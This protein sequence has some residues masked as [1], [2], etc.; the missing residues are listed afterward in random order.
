MASYSFYLF[1]RSIESF[2]L[3]TL[4]Q[5]RSVKTAN[6]KS[7]EIRKK[8]RVKDKSFALFESLFAK[9]VMDNLQ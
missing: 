9:Y 2:R 4:G 5:M 7:G 6:I 8:T 1:Y 3:I